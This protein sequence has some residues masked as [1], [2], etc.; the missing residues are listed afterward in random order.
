MNKHPRVCVVGSINMDMVTTTKKM[1]EQGETVIGESFETYPGG[2]GA[3]QAV[4]AARLGANVSIIGAVG[5]DVFGRSLITHFQS[6]GVDQEGIQVIPN[7]S[8]GIATIILSENDNRILVSS[9]ANAKLTPKIVN[10]SY[11]ILLASDVILLQFEIPMETVQFTVDFAYKH[12][13]PVIINP[14]P[15]R[16]I[17][18]DILRKVT[19]LTPNEVELLSMTK[20]RLF[21][22]VKGKMIVTRGEK[23]VQFVASSGVPETIPAYQVSVK[24]TTG[25]GDTF[26]G[27]LATELGRTK[28]IDQ[29]VDFAN[30]AAALSVERLGAQGG[31][32]TRKDVIRFIEKTKA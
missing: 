26:N 8:T 6:E 12:H 11:E 29:S 25:A 20:M 19:Y 5:D 1:P 13:I 21:E 23:G 3:N 31:M 10:D 32:P 9:N 28:L 15:F 22:S 7:I 24:D 2:K 30:A 27:A 16:E 14:A 18:E 17:P 4:A